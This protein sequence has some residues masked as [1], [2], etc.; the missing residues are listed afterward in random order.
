MGLFDFFK[1][2]RRISP[3]TQ[4]MIDRIKENSSS[5]EEK[6]VVK[7]DHVDKKA[8]RAKATAMIYEGNL[9]GAIEY[10]TNFKANYQYKGKG[11]GFFLDFSENELKEIFNKIKITTVFSDIGLPGPYINRFR[12]VFYE[13]YLFGDFNL[14]KRF[15]D[16]L[17]G[18]VD[19]IKKSRIIKNKDGPFVDIKNRI[20]GF[21]VFNHNY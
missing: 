9:N 20:R 8:A 1:R 7:N 13:L 5:Q 12:D 3:K 14:E 18:S 19:I 10:Y 21:K 11:S 17:P 15:E 4:I 2:K 6:T 16:I